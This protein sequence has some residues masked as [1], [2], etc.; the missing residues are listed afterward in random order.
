MS[1]REEGGPVHPCFATHD[2]YGMTLRDYF[3][4]NAPAE[5]PPWFLPAD[6]REATAEASNKRLADR[7]FDWR[8]F[9]ADKMVRESAK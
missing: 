5:V 9:Y 7:W 1:T 4:A 2:H 8:W 6:L 3:A